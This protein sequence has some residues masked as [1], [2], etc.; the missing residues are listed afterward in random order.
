LQAGYGVADK[1]RKAEWSFVQM[2]ENSKQ[3]GIREKVVEKKQRNKSTPGDSDTFFFERMDTH[4]EE[5]IM[6]QI[7][8]VG[9]KK[10]ILNLLFFRGNRRKQGGKRS[11]DF[12]P[13]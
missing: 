12:F 3:T 1:R 11:K 6:Q 7:L 10:K 4:D 9:T 5:S 8:N 13:L 2:G